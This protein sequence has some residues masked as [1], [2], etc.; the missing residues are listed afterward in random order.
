MKENDMDWTF[1]IFE[2]MMQ[3]FLHSYNKKTQTLFKKS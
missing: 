1:C 3:L 2:W